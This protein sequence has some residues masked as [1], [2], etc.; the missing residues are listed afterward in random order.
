MIPGT[1]ADSDKSSEG[2]HSSELSE[3][4][5]LEMLE[6]ELKEYKA[7]TF[8]GNI[9]S[10][11]FFGIPHQMCLACVCLGT[12]APSPRGGGHTRKPHLGQCC[13]LPCTFSGSLHMCPRNYSNYTFPCFPALVFFCFCLPFFLH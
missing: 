13:E 12:Q 6:Q 2:R 7:A 1:R 4:E 5:I 10:S 8:F 11:P 3:D 9:W